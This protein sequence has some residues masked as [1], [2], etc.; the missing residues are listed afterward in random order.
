MRWKSL[1]Q[2]NIQLSIEDNLKV[3]EIFY[4]IQGESTFSG[5]PCIFVRLSGCNLNCH[6]CDT[7]YAKTETPKIYFMKQ[8]I[9]KINGYNCRLIEFTGGEPLLQK[10]CLV[11]LTEY[12][13]NQNYTVLLETN[14]S[15]SLDGIPMQVIKIIDVKTP[16]SGECKSFNNENFQFIDKQRDQL[17]FVIADRKDFL[18]M[19][20]FLSKNDQKIPT[21]IISSPILNQL[22]LEKLADW[23]K[24]SPYRIRLQI[25]LH[26]LIWDAQR[27][28]V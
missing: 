20:Q 1:S 11:K 21:E 27:R 17:K 22:K 28:A 15:I 7:L 12:L 13:V 26:K 14:G 6:W 16:S 2:I 4:S 10:K 18:F 9:E 8:L 19:E 23:I 5:L 24:K 3:N 25:Q